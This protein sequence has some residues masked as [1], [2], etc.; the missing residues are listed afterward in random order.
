MTDRNRSLIR[1]PECGGELTVDTATGQILDHRPAAKK[2]PG[3]VFDELVADLDASKSRADEIFAQELG[4]LEDRDRLMDEKFR[5]A[6]KRAEEA[7]DDGK[8]PA[9]PFDFD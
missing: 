8:P 3:K 2:R 6:L 9:R 4:A 5:Q 7:G 1:C